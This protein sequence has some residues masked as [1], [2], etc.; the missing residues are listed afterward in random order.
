MKN[1][2]ISTLE[3]SWLTELPTTCCTKSRLKVRENENHEAQVYCDWCGQN[4]DFAPTI[5]GACLNWTREN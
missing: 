5:E 4:C 2:K 1:L 3:K